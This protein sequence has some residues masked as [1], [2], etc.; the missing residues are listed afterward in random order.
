MRPAFVFEPMVCRECGKTIAPSSQTGGKASSPSASIYE[1]ACGFRYSNNRDPGSRTAFAPTAAQNVPKRFRS[2]LNETLDAAA[3]IGNRASKRSKFTYSTS[4]DAV[5]WTVFRWLQHD[6]KLGLV[7][8]AV[9]APP[10]QGDAEILFWGAPVGGQPT[11]LSEQLRTICLGIDGNADRLTEPD[12]VIAWQQ[13]LFFIE[14]KYTGKNEHKPGYKH[15]PLYTTGPG[16]DASSRCN[17]PRSGRKVGT[18]SRG[19]G[20]SAHSSRSSA[21]RASR[22]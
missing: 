10:P 11:E 3:N 16:A 21:K 15:F 19:T 2:Q 20:G 18:S 14:V 7:A 17:R 22:W 6:S 13:D 4:E 9:G 1:C 5:T 8:E 12:V